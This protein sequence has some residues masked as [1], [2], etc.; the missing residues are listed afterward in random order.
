MASLTIGAL[1]LG[2]VNQPETVDLQCNLWKKS[3]PG[4]TSSTGVA[5]DV[6]GKMRFVRITGTKTG[7]LAQLKTWAE[8]IDF[9]AND[10]IQSRKVLTLSSGITFNV[11]CDSFKYDLYVNKA[12]Y[13]MVLLESGI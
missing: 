3:L 11:R 4:Q 9:W 6:F 8:D 5:V 2:V 12:K 10:N 13:V 7:S 1:D